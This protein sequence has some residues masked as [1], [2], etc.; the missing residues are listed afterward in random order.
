VLRLSYIADTEDAALVSRR[1]DAILRQVTGGWNA[2]KDG[3]VLT[4]E[5]EV[6]WRLGAPPARPD[7]RAPESR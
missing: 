5:R 6:F 1:V 7:V 3:Y 2:T 4:I